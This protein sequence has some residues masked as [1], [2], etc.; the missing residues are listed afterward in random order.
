MSGG[1][2]KFQQLIAGPHDRTSTLIFKDAYTGAETPLKPESGQVTIDVGATNR[3]VLAVGLAPQQSVFDVLS[4]AG[5]E[6]TATQTYRYTD[7]TT[8]T[9]QLGVFPVTQQSMNYRP[10]GSLDLQCPDRWRNVTSNGFGI[11]RSSVASNMAWQ[12]ARRLIEGAFPNP[13]FPFPGWAELDESATD[14]VGSQIWTD[15]DRDAATG[16]ILK[17]S[18]LDAYFNAQ[19]LCVLHPIPTPTSKSTPVCVIRAGVGGLLNDADRQMDLTSVH[20][21]ILLSTSASDIILPM[22]EVA[23]TNDPA[24]DQLSSLGKLGRVTLEVSSA[25]FRSTTQMRAAGRVILGRELSVVVP[26]DITASGANPYLDGYDVFD[27]ILPK[28]DAGTIRPAQRHVA[29]VITIPLTQNDKQEISVRAAPA[30]YD[31]ITGEAA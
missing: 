3:R 21:V 16:G 29:E 2:T 4:S 28:G 13:A 8:E 27:T 11:S 6:I 14:K 19:G 15:G 23:N 12:E 20:N 30:T 26:L 31:D 18:A 24:V 25:N 17:S 10:D 7:H 22:V 9:V 1:S 5:G